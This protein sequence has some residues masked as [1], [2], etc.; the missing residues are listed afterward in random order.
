MPISKARRARLKKSFSRGTGGRAIQ[1]S[2]RR[3]PKKAD[4]AK[5][6]IISLYYQIVSRIVRKRPEVTP[7]FE[8]Q[9]ENGLFL[10][11]ELGLAYIIAE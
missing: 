3:K 11:N 1:F 8:L 9:L 10:V 5:A 2:Q 7:E 6:L 4:I